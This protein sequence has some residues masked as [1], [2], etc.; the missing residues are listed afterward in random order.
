MHLY[1]FY[2]EKAFATKTPKKL[3]KKLKER[4]NYKI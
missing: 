3:Q 4:K 2:Q 1:F